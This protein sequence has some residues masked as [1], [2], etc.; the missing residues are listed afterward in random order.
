MAMKLEARAS[1]ARIFKCPGCGLVDDGD[2]SKFNVTYNPAGRS[3][4][5]IIC[6]R[7]SCRTPVEAVM[8]GERLWV[9]KD[10]RAMRLS[11]METSHI[12]NCIAK[13]IVNPSWK[14]GW[15]E[16]L[17]KE[18]EKRKGAANSDTQSSVTNESETGS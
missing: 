2:T 13:I 16:A 11:D 3:A 7:C 10:R 9:T 14:M 6:K 4:H 5:T 1:T 17:L 18:L 15:A 12:E 8:S